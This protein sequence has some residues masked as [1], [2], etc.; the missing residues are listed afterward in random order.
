MNDVEKVGKDR[1]VLRRRLNEL[2]WRRKQREEIDER[3]RGKL[4]NKE[5]KERFRR[6]K[7]RRKKKTELEVDQYG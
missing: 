5:W 7:E 4:G 6:T 1:V 2:D 3:G